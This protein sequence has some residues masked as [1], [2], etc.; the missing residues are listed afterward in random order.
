VLFLGFDGR[1]LRSV[2]VEPIDQTEP[3]VVMGAQF[4]LRKSGTGEY[5]FGLRAANGEKILSGETYTSR[6]AAVAG[7][8]SV[9]TNAPDDAR[10]ERKLSSASQPYFVLNAANGEPIGTSE[11]YS[12]AAARDGGIAA[13]KQAAPVAALDDH[14]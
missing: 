3:G 7:I 8:E 2:V 14:T 10:Y 1:S 9:R 11:M 4:E 12:S 5:H 6:A 13:V